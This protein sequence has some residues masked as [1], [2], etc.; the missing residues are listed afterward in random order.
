[1]PEVSN[2]SLLNSFPWSNHTLEA[3]I[4]L[5]NYKLTSKN[6]NEEMCLMILQIMVVN[7]NPRK[8]FEVTSN[9]DAK[10]A[11]ESSLLTIYAILHAHGDSFTDLFELRK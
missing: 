11:D 7:L 2:I 4:Q 10:Q 9:F 1:M 6:L 8:I 3:Q 5:Q